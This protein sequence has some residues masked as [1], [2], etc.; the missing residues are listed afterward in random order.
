MPNLQVTLCYR[1]VCIGKNSIYGVW[2][3]LWFQADTGSV[4]M[5]CPQIRGLLYL[6][7]MY[8]AFMTNLLPYIV[9]SALKGLSH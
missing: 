2:F 7:F 9:T 4:E 1:Y 5:Y 3:Y 8:L 6:A